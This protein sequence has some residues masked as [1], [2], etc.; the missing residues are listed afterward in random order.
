MSVSAASA[1]HVASAPPAGASPVLRSGEGFGEVLAAV[2]G[3]TAEA[4]PPRPGAAT[5]AAGVATGGSLLGTA[6]LILPTRAAVQALAAELAESLSARFAAAGIAEDPPVTITVDDTGGIHVAGDRDDLAAVRSLIDSDEGLQRRIRD[7]NAIASH[8]QAMNAERT[9]A[10]QQAY[11]A[12]SDPAAVVAQFA[13]VFA[14]RPAVMS[15]EFGG[16]RIA[17]AADGASWIAGQ[18]A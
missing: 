13:D 17:V 14:A 7:T 9:L 15:L 3:G 18:D 10:F 6:T 5:G 1:V 11:R 8:A 16:G 12:S 4:A 2:V